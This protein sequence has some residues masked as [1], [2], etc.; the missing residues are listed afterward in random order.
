ME[1]AFWALE[2]KVPED[3][4]SPSEDISEEVE[5]VEEGTKPDS[6]DKDGGDK[7]DDIWNLELFENKPKSEPAWSGSDADKTKL[8]K[9]IELPQAVVPK[10]K[11]HHLKPQRSLSHPSPMSRFARLPPSLLECTRRLSLKPDPE[12]FASDTYLY[13]ILWACG[14]LIFWKNITLLPLL[15]LPIIIYIM[16][17][18]GI[19]LGLW[20]WIG[21]QFT[22][23]GNTVYD[24]CA[25]RY[26]ALVP[27][28]IRGLYKISLKMNRC[29]KDGVRNSID[30]VSSVV[31]ILGLIVFMICASVFFAIQVNILFFVVF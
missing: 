22:T 20:Q 7:T 3:S 27:V 19:Y 15:P 26:D 23:L 10:T 1:A 6:G 28:P 21:T 30:T 14:A 8:R 29:V 2:N 12:S 17:H 25:A 16:K 5:N 11:I 4:Q 18:F 31:V 13:I 24:W 9:T